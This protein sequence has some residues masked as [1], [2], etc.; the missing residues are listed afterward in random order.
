MRYFYDC[1]FIEDGRTIDLISIGIVADDGRHYYAVN[2]DA[3]WDRIRKHRWL[4]DNVWPQLPLRGYKQDLVIVGGKTRTKLTKLGVINTEDARVRPRWV[5]ANEVR[6]FLLRDPR[7]EIELWAWYAAYDHVVLA[8][9]FGPM[10]SLPKGIPMW[11]HDVQQEAHRLGV[12]VE[13]EVPHTGTAHHAL[14]DAHWTKA[15][16]DHL[17]GVER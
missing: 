2:S 6:D 4:A 15:M 14:A 17:K 13:D 9:L 16:H 3:D 12:D 7:E 1:E 11:T 5:I 8:Q 10:I